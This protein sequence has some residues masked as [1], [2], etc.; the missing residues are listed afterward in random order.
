MATPTVRSPYSTPK[1][2][3]A[4]TSRH[5]QTLPVESSVAL[6][7]SLKM[8]LPQ[9][10][11]T[12]NTSRA[13]ASADAPGAPPSTTAG[14]APPSTIAGRAPLSST[15]ASADNMDPFVDNNTMDVTGDNDT[16][17]DADD[18]YFSNFSFTRP[19]HPIELIQPS[20]AG[21]QFF[22]ITIG[23]PIGIVGSLDAVN[24]SQQTQFAV[25]QF[26]SWYAAVGFYAVHFYSGNVRLVPALSEP[27][28]R[29]LI[30]RRLAPQDT[31]SAVPRPPAPV[32]G[33]AA[34]P[35][36]VGTPLN[37]TPVSTQ[38]A[39]LGP[40]LTQTAG[41]GPVSTQSAVTPTP[42]GRIPREAKGKAPLCTP[43]KYQPPPLKP[44]QTRIRK[45]SST[46]R[47]V[48][49]VS[50]TDDDDNNNKSNNSGSSNDN[51]AAPPGQD[52]P[53]DGAMNTTVN[54]AID[55]VMDTAMDTAVDAAIDAAVGAAVDDA[56]G[57]VSDVGVDGAERRG[58]VVY[59]SDEEGPDFL[60][61]YPQGRASG[62]GTQQDAPTTPS[63]TQSDRAL[64]Q[65]SPSET[66]IPETA[67]VT[68]LTSAKAF[69]VLFSDTSDSG[70]RLD[71]AHILRSGK[72][73][74]LTPQG[75]S[76][77]LGGAD[78]MSPLSSLSCSTTSANASPVSGPSSRQNNVHTPTIASPASGPSSH[79]NVQT[80]AVTTPT[81]PPVAGPSSQQNIQMP[82][83]MSPTTTSGQAALAD[84]NAS[85]SSY[86]EYDIS[87]IDPADLE[88][89]GK[90]MDDAWEHSTRK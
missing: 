33:S 34:N 58:A 88:A 11:Q 81:G 41:L 50:D 75:R 25:T 51:S 2:R 89:I 72:R 13:A 4:R 62:S 67:P 83:V 30:L 55:A 60:P 45:R 69:V 82:T 66:E 46:A 20:T 80:S 17:D 49:W 36:Y 78:P 19:P 85:V 53:I 14:R 42:H 9:A 10:N 32:A 43:F 68:P 70:P 31:S 63:N 47:R 71:L 37:G 48:I 22:V 28:H 38:T 16:D 1:I 35:I 39:G 24:L 64:P 12:N 40:V 7:T 73:Y 79:Q 6:C 77:T 87:E 15:V 56:L 76:L 52:S 86:S 3:C 23:Q 54:V 59:G 27:P 8:Q 5:S 57:N 29:A 18:D 61:T 90:A 44:A 84:D 65:V 26:T 21:I 74:R